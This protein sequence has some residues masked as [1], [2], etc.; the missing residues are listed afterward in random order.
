M[1]RYPPARDRRHAAGATGDA[2]TSA[3]ISVGIAGIGIGIY[4]AVDQALMTQVLPN[5]ADAGKDL[6]V[7]NVAQAGGQVIAP[8]AASLIIGLLGYQ[9]LYMFAGG[10]QC[11]PR[12]RSF[13]SAA[14][15]RSG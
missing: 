13:P 11:S 10:W 14:C 12:S 2:A 3:L 9:G 1:A 7:L 6:G 15:D 4:L 8:L 5:S